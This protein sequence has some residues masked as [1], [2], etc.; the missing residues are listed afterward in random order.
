MA[1]IAIA[2]GLPR[3]G[4]DIEILRTRARAA[5]LSNRFF[6][7][8]EAAWVRA[9]PDPVIRSQ[10]FLALWTAKEAL[11]KA[12]GRGLAYGLD[13]VRFR[14]DAEAPRA[15]C[16]AGDIAEGGEWRFQRIDGIE[17]YT[18]TLAWQGAARQLVWKR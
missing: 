5:E 17:G 15:E 13:R 10:R 1:C 7:P 14:I 3:L 18:G 16:L 12:H 4:V 6:A 9:I 2:R 11:L 8:D